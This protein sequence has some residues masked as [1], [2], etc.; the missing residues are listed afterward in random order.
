VVS[1]ADPYGCNV[2]FQKNKT[3]LCSLIRVHKAPALLKAFIFLFISQS[4]RGL[5][6]IQHQGPSLLKADAKT[7]L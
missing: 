3:F 2:G 7:K 1:A 6:E 4:F 5:P